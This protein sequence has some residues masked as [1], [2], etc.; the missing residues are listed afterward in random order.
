MKKLVLF[1]LFALF[2]RP[3]IAQWNFN[4]EGEELDACRIWDGNDF[5]GID[6]FGRIVVTGPL[7]DAE[8]RATAV[9]VSG[10]LTDTQL[11]ATPVPV[12]GTVTANTG[13][14]T[15]TQLR[16]TPVPV[17]GT[18][19]A[20]TGG[21]T[22]TQ[23]RATAVPV[24]GPLTDTQLRATAVPVSGPLTDAQLRA[25]PVPVSGS[26]SMTNTNRT[27]SGT[28]GALNATVSMT[29]DG[30]NSISFEIDTG[31]VGTMLAEGTIDGT[32]YF[33]LG[34]FD[35]VNLDGMN[36]ITNSDLPFR[37]K[38]RV[39][40]VATV[41]LRVSAYTSGSS[42]ARILG[43]TGG[44]LFPPRYSAAGSM[45]VDGSG[46]TQPVS[47]AGGSLTVDGT[48][49]TSPPANA[50]TNISQLGGS[51]I[52][53]NTGNAS[54]GV[55]RVVIA[56]D[57]PQ[58]TNALKV[59]GSAVTQPVSGPLTDT[60]L[61]A[62]PVPVS[63]TVTATG[64]LTDTQLRAT[65]VPVSGTV[66]ADSE[67]PAAAAL[68]DNTANPTAPAVG[69]FLQ[70]WDGSNWDRVQTGAATGGALKVDGSAVT[71]PVSGPLTDTQLRATAVPVSGPLTD[72]QLRATPVP[73][74]G[75]V[76]ATGPLT[77]T[78]LRATAVPVS[79]TVTA[80]GTADTELPAAA[81]FADN[82]ANPTAPAVGGFL[83][84]WDGTNWDRVQTGA[85]SGGALKVD[86]SAV[87]Q[88]VS[89]TVTAT[90]PLTDTQLR[91]TAVPVSGTVTVTDG[92]GA[93]NVIV[94]SGSI[95]ADTEAPAAAALADNTANPTVPA[96]G[97]FNMAWDG[98]NWDRLQT[99]AATGGALKVDGSAVTQPVSGTV[100]ATGPLTDTQLRAT[101][102]PVD[103]ELPAAAALADNTSNPTVP[104][105]ADFM[106]AWDVVGGNWDRVPM[107]GGASG[108][109]RVD[110]SL[111]T[112]PIKGE[113]ADDAAV[114][115][116]PVLVG[117][118]AW[119]DGTAP[120]AVSAGGDL[121][122]MLATPQGILVVT[123]DHPKRIRC[124][125]EN[126]SATILTAFGS[127]CAAPGAG[128]SIYVTGIAV[129]SS[130]AATTTAANYFR[131]AYGT[132]GTCGTGTTIIWSMYNSVNNP[133]IQ[134]P[135]EPPLKLAANNELCWQHAVAGSKNLNITGYIAP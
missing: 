10:P 33:N 84:A 116:N 13:G 127:D 96:S 20:N 78:Q 97:S 65:P 19:T 102:V 94:D 106:M 68:A 35:I 66:T 48:V 75:T 8:L 44:G 37:G 117:A 29:T 130:A 31:I 115:A 50:S 82:T 16:A 15:D 46:V 53:V 69:S 121:T 118:E 62:T 123:T 43:N 110:A 100:T 34:V 47:D 128:L 73:V 81:A 105:V 71:Q 111:N 58:L 70:A 30:L 125:V 27:A 22:D 107:T 9:P 32:N 95:T 24:S 67:L 5:L 80:N 3:A 86:G 108:G 91:A 57:Q 79:G 126:S 88:P 113:I 61:R 77:D 99:G 114:G 134:S 76:T 21:L 93:L 98:T 133:V 39:T 17:S 45:L 120:S 14:L 92:A 4:G 41:R 38:V 12:S 51:V 59:D 104:G 6:A 131:L 60:Q 74:S 26:M 129:T 64:G 28:L 2:A 18:V 122:R 72:T 40:D 109:I 124:T 11:R 87:T 42:S 36:N 54:N 55:A 23:L 112:L 103:T 89:G 85:A 56:T 119:T 132:G 90:G 25:T 1:A 52:A 135:I 83:H 7:T 49:T 63:G 101:S